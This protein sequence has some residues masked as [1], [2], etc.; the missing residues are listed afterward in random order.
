MRT[1]GRCSTNASCAAART[2]SRPV[3]TTGAGRGRPTTPPV[4][5]VLDDPDAWHP[6]D[7]LLVPLK[8]SDGSLLGVMSVDEPDSLRRPDDGELDVLVARGRPRRARD[9]GRAGGRDRRAARRV[10]R[11]PSAGVVAPGR[12]AQRRHDAPVRRRRDPARA[13]VRA[14]LDRARASG[15]RRCSFRALQRAGELGGPPPSGL[16]R[17]TIA[18]LFD[19]DYEV[20]GCYLLPFEVASARMSQS[21][22][23]STLNGTG[24]HAW[25]RHWLVVPLQDDD[26]TLQGFIWADDPGDRLLPTREKMQAL[27]LFANQAST[28]LESAARVRGASVPRRPRSAHEAAEPARVRAPA[29]EPRRRARC[30][31]AMRSRSCCATSTSSRS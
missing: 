5:P 22:Y 14:R 10:A 23:A 20:E 6:E 7:V 8:T 2:S 18:P 30:A 29:R 13:R 27:R 11:A 9:R 17:E 28:A 12:D 1:S 16:T 31:T 21:R 3:R 24:P 15:R 25:S 4:D 26:G 19:P